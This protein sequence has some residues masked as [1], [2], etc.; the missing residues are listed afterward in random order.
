MTTVSSN[1]YRFWRWN[2]SKQIELEISYRGVQFLAP[3][4]LCSPSY[5]GLKVHVSQNTILEKWKYGI[6]RWNLSKKIGLEMSRRGV[7]FLAPE[8]LCSP[9]YEGL[10]VQN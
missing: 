7:Q 9:S 2:L 5:E 3:E 1:M 8:S 4:S 10:K 6:W